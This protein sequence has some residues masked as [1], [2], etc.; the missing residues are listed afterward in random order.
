VHSKNKTPILGNA[1]SVL[2]MKL[3][4]GQYVFWSFFKIDLCSATSMESS[5]QDLLNDM[6]EQRSI[7]KTNQNTYYP[8]F[9]FTPKT[10]V[11]FPKTGVSFLL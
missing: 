9:S 1:V 2:G 7:L 3:K 8:R 10:C 11:S 6:A 4:Q 5:R